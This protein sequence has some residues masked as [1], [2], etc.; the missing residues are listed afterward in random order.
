MDYTELRRQMVTL[1]EEGFDDSFG[2]FCGKTFSSYSYPP[3]NLTA[4][5]LHGH[6]LRLAIAAIVR[7]ETIEELL[8]HESAEDDREETVFWKVLGDSIKAA[9]ESDRPFIQ[10]FVEK[11]CAYF[12]APDSSLT[13]S[14]RG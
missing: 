1:Q 11:W 3:E 9:L 2:A 14:G 13:E 5:R 4:A 6:Y 7:S 12:A 10:C 8:S